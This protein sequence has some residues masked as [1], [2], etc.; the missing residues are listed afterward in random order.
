VGQQRQRRENLLSIHILKIAINKKEER[1][2]KNMVMSA[3]FLA[4]AAAACLVSVKALAI[5]PEKDQVIVFDNPQ[6][7]GE[8]YMTMK[9]ADYED[10]RVYQTSGK[11]SPT[12]DNAVSCMKIGEGLKVRVYEK[13][14]F[15]GKNKIFS[16]TA[17]N[18]GLVSL[19]DTPW[20][21]M[22][23]SLKIY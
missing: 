22:I 1:A 9:K 18:N 16:R 14:N 21:N 19:A 7:Q 10:M 11:D 2:M 15:K 6:C 5:E 12:W 23:S 20:D 8:P 13:A 3:V 17:E 4:L